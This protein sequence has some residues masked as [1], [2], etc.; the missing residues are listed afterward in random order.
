MKTIS[1]TNGVQVSK[2]LEGEPFGRQLS[3]DELLANLMR[4]VTEGSSSGN[5]S[6]FH[7]QNEDF[8]ALPGANHLGSHSISQQVG[9][10]FYSL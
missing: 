10:L 6:E 4:G 2:T 7:I 1:T 3:D 5:N 8:P 9:W